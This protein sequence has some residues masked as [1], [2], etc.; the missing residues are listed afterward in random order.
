[1]VALLAPP[2]FPP[3]RELKARIEKIAATQRVGVTFHEQVEVSGPR[4]AAVQYARGIPSVWI[5][6]AEVEPIKGS[7]P[8]FTVRTFAA[9]DGSRALLPSDATLE[10]A[11]AAEAALMRGDRRA[12]VYARPYKRKA[13]GDA[14]LDCWL[15][16]HAPDEHLARTRTAALA[17]GLNDAYDVFV[18]KVPAPAHTL[19]RTM[20]TRDLPGLLEEDDDL[21][22]AAVEAAYGAYERVTELVAALEAR[23]PGI[24]ASDPSTEAALRALFAQVARELEGVSEEDATFARAVAAAPAVMEI[25]RS[26]EAAPLDAPCVNAC[27]H[28][29]LHRLW[30]TSADGDPDAALKEARAR[31]DAAVEHAIRRHD[32]RDADGNAPSCYLLH[33]ELAARYGRPFPVVPAVPS[34]ASKVADAVAAAWE[35]ALAAGLSEIEAAGKSLAAAERAAAG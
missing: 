13:P 26:M 25:S 8:S 32:E 31:F 35:A 6:G 1:M 20:A 5:G 4:D 28:E 34:G 23:A 18:D 17:T 11:I 24:T 2:G 33:G 3:L 29:A 22:S 14:A 19:V 12:K 15:A 9:A 16:V 7:R 27:A 30:E 21:P 10:A